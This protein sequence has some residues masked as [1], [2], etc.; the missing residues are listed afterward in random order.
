METAP[1]PIVT[2]WDMGNKRESKRQPVVLLMRV[3]PA[4]RLVTAYRTY[5]Q[6]AH[7][8]CGKRGSN[9]YLAT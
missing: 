3:K 5:H 7:Q 6:P 1:K 4:G 9:P 2:T 8:P